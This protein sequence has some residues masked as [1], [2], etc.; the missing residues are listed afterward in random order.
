[1]AEESLVSGRVESTRRRAARPGNRAGQTRIDRTPPVMT[2][3]NGIDLAP[4][5]SHMHVMLEVIDSE[6]RDRPLHLSLARLKKILPSDVI[7]LCLTLELARE[8]GF[9][10]IV[11]EAP[12]PGFMGV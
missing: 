3:V 6:P 4:C 8:M 10:S 2:P 5:L 12:P 11:V 7:N 1:M 9:P